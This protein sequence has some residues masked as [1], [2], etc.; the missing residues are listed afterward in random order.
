MGR[1]HR[2]PGEQAGHE[3]HHPRPAVVGGGVRSLVSSLGLRGTNYFVGYTAWLD[4]APEG[5]SKASG[6]A[7]VAERL[8]VRRPDGSRSATA[9]TTSRC[10]AWAGRGVAMGQ[11]PDEVKAVADAVTGACRTTGR[12]RGAGR[13]FPVTERLGR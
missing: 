5:I 8:G 3:G 13:W 10:S 2:Q 11:A 4:L 1:V 6:L 12:L 9:A 7:Q